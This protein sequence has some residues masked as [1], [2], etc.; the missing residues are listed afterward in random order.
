MEN[1]A[2]AGEPTIREAAGDG[3]A[4]PIGRGPFETAV[5]FSR[6][7]LAGDAAAA[8]TYFSPLGRLLTPDGTELSGRTSITE[9]LGQFATPDHKLEI[10]TG[11]VV[12]AD[13]I[14][15]CKQYWRRSSRR[16]DVEQYETA[17]IARLVLQRHEIG[18]LIMVAAPW[19]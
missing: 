5:A 11:R 16:S 8:A 15:L 2:P 6:A 13:S 12:Q 1:E 3:H 14:A 7:L 10:R 19:E 9:L 17:S 4:G 18:W